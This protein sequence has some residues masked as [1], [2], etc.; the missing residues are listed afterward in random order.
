MS[1]S[2][3]Q[4]SAN[5]SKKLATN[6]ATGHISRQISGQVSG[7]VSGQITVQTW[8]RQSVQNF[9]HEVNWSGHETLPTQSDRPWILSVQQYFG[10]ISWTGVATVAAPSAKR[11][12]QFDAETVQPE[13]ETLDNFL[14]D[15]SQFF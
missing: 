13:R 12:S 2:I 11:S 4:S 6:Q 10:L 3:R 9:W 14:E 5:S 1:S 15:I 8:H 7:Q